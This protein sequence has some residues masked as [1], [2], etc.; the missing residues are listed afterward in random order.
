M[1]QL[2]LF[3]GDHHVF[4]DLRKH[5][6][7]ASGTAM[8]RVSIYTVSRA[9]HRDI[10]AF[11]GVP[12]EGFISR[13]HSPIAPSVKIQLYIDT[14]TEDGRFI[15]CRRLTKEVIEVGT[16]GFAFSLVQ[17]PSCQCDLTCVAGTGKGKQIR[18]VVEKPNSCRTPDI[19][20]DT[21][22]LQ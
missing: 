4:S 1:S 21:T 5:Q 2:A 10:K 8:I 3:V 9:L 7:D 16:L 6:S 22:K 20:C 15:F 13:H 11:T 19:C 18:A 12:R 14:S 17:Q